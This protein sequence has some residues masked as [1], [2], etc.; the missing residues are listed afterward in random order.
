MK[1]FSL[2]LTITSLCCLLFSIAGFAQQQG[3]PEM[4][5]LLRSNG[6]IYVVV[7]VLVIIFIGIIIYLIS[8]DRKVHKLEK[9]ITPDQK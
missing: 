8:I 4:A 1:N 6:K 9:R 2:R 3:K 7:G 5:T